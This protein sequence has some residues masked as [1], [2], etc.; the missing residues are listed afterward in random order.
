MKKIKLPKSPDRLIKT[1]FAGNEHFPQGDYVTNGHWLFHVPTICA[2]P[3][4]PFEKS[5]D[6][7]WS[8]TPYGRWINDIFVKDDEPLS[9]AS[10]LPRNIEEYGPC[11]LSLIHI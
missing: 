6:S 1:C 7:I 8:A 10:V 4:K 9:I 2:Y 11:E 3:N 5:L